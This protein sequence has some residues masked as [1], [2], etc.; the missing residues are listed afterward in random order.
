MHQPAGVGGRL[1]LSPKAQT[2]L[3]DNSEAK[4]IQKRQIEKKKKTKMGFNAEH[5]ADILLHLDL[6][7]PPNQNTY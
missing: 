7:P 1:L 5:K 3:E 4:E 6:N 2:G